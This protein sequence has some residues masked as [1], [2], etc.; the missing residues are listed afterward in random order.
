MRAV[1]QIASAK[2]SDST[3]MA[4]IAD[5]QQCMHKRDWKFHPIRENRHVTE[6]R[7]KKNP[8]FSMDLQIFSYNA[9][10]TF[11]RWT[12]VHYEQIFSSFHY[13]DFI[14]N[15]PC[16]PHISSASW[17]GRQRRTRPL[18]T[19]EGQASTGPPPC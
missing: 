16:D 7:Y 13:S 2:R 19:D 9:Y 6:I 1:N 10:G 8:T 12:A 18:A 11:T 3:R 15:M 14:P 5:M 4:R 17:L